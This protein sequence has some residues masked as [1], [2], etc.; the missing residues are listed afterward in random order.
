VRR[1]LLVALGAAAMAAAAQAVDLQ[2][3]LWEVSTTSARNG[4]STPRPARTLCMTPE[5]AKAITA[6]IAKA[7]P[8][9][10]FSSR[11]TTCKIV[12]LRETE[13]EVTWRTQCTGQFPAEQT[14]RYVVDNPQHYTNTVRSSVKGVKKTLSSTLTTEGRR[15]GECPK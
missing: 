11:N 2:A 12:D 15:V 9:D 8:T 10:T 14:G 3:G 7:L 1:L 4:V 6:Q 13:K 5:K